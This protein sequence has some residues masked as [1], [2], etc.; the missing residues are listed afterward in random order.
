MFDIRVL[1]P[2]GG[3]SVG[4]SFGKQAGVGVVSNASVFWGIEYYDEKSGD[5]NGFKFWD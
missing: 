1:G 3:T 5:I 4:I 2:T